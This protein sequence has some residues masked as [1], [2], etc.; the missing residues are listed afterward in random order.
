MDKTLTINDRQR[1]SRLLRTR[2]KA[3]GGYS[4]VATKIGVS[5]QR[6]WNWVS[7]DHAIPAELCA[8]IEA[9]TGIAKSDLR[10]DIWGDDNG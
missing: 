8:S 6:F 5:R 3:L 10:P 1:A 9:V 4:R 2:A 7:F